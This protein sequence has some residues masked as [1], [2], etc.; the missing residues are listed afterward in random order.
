MDLSELRYQSNKYFH[1]LV[2]QV[3]VR[4][5]YLLYMATLAL[6]AVQNLRELMIRHATI[7]DD[8]LLDRFRWT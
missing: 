8:Q 5:H 2:A 7:V 4:V 3:V 1:A 6:D